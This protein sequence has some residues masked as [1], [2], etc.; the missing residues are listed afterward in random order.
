MLSKWPGYCLRTGGLMVQAHA[1]AHGIDTIRPTHDVDMLLHLQLLTGLPGEAVA[2]LN[3]SATSCVSRCSA[4][5]R[6][7]DSERPGPH[8]GEHGID[9]IDLLSPD[10]L[11][12]R[13]ATLRRSPMLEIPGGRQALDRTALFVLTTADGAEVG[14]S[15]PDEL[16]ALVLKGAAHQA[17]RTPER[18]RH[19][20]DAAVLAATLTDHGA[21]RARLKGSDRKRLRHLAAELANPAIPAGSNS[22]NPTA[23]TVRTAC[24]SSPHQP[25]LAQPRRQASS[26]PPPPHARVIHTM[27]PRP[28][29]STDSRRTS[30]VPH[31]RS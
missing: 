20:L 14:F 7:T 24:G 31:Y 9:R 15:I 26:L 29:L 22:P 25:E 23:P 6:P 27:D 13:T 2:A 11:G 1:L 21:E 18:Q 8:Q 4:R 30:P 17:D 16:G 3:H 19:L 12:H 28:K 10:H 5:V